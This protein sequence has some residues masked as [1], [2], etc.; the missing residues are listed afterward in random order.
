MEEGMHLSHHARQRITERHLTIEEIESTINHGA[1]IKEKS[2]SNTIT[3]EHN[4]VWVV[5]TT[6]WEPYV[7]TAFIK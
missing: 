1:I 4:G 7:I 2:S 5:A 3:V 6:G